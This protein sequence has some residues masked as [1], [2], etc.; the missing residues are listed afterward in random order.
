MSKEKDGGRR[1]SERT[2]SPIRL[3][4][5]ASLEDHH[6]G[7]SGGIQSPRASSTTHRSEHEVR[8]RR[9]FAHPVR[10]RSMLDE[11]GLFHLAP[12]PYKQSRRRNSGQ[13]P[14][15]D[16]GFSRDDDETRNSLSQPPFASFS[17]PPP[18]T[19]PL[20]PAHHRYPSFF[21]PSFSLRSAHLGSRSRIPLRGLLPPPGAP[22][23]PPKNPPPP[24]APAL[25]LSPAVEYDLGMTWIECRLG[26]LASGLAVDC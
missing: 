8:R 6:Q 18:C 23:P 3:S 1:Q 9:E 25:A 16:S 13:L 11:L 5:F 15:L 10:S 22:P 24:P 12:A 14:F 26:R 2:K 17:P 7:I 4:R 19:F 20:P 21:L